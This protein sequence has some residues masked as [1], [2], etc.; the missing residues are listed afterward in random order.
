MQAFHANQLGGGHWGC[1]PPL[2]TLRDAFPQVDLMDV[3]LEDG[4]AS[5]IQR[6]VGGLS[7]VGLPGSV[8]KDLLRGG[9]ID[10]DEHGRAFAREYLLRNYLKAR[11]VLAA[12][13]IQPPTSIIDIGCGSGAF[14]AAVLVHLDQAN[15]SWPWPDRRL[16]RTTT[17]RI[18]LVDQSSLQLELAA[19]LL[20]WLRPALSTVGFELEMHRADITA[21][22]ADALQGL[23][24][25]AL[26]GHVA[27]ENTERLDVFL[28]NALATLAPGGE[29]MV[30]ERSDD[31]VGQAILSFAEG[32]ALSPIARQVE[33]PSRRFRY[34][35]QW[36][37]ARQPV[38]DVH[39]DVLQAYF[40]AWRTRSPMLI[41]QLFAPDADYAINNKLAYRGHDE[42]Q[43]Y[44]REKVMPQVLLHLNIESSEVLRQGRVR[45]AWESRFL[46]GRATTVCGELELE[47]DTRARRVLGLEEWYTKTPA[48]TLGSS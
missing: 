19:S 20:E 47:I 26:I 24:D 40:R 45:A 36:L 33:R 13:A 12:C 38:V 16:P 30:I 21:G 41:E 48:T 3:L 39:Q 2:P 28:S 10:Y 42:I 31:P 32:L 8:R 4:M 14:I 46:K 6:F 7:T 43:R 35:S 18:V 44:W 29:A 1:D 15:R 22:E 11:Y 34:A 27:T 5:L 37:N 23:F 25:L 17:F 9:G